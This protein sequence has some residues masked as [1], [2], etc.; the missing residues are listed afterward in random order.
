[1]NLLFACAEGEVSFKNTVFILEVSNDKE[2]GLQQLEKVWFYMKPR[3]AETLVFVLS[4]VKRNL[5]RDV[6]CHIT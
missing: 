3:F 2:T 5:I 1:M 6:S 4:K